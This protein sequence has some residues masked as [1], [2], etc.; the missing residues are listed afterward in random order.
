MDTLGNNPLGYETKYPNS[1]TLD[2]DRD[3]ITD[4]IFNLSGSFGNMSGYYVT[5]KATSVNGSVIAFNTMHDTT[6]SQVYIDSIGYTIHYYYNKFDV[7]R[8]FGNL[9]TISMMRKFTSKT[10]W[11]SEYYQMGSHSIPSSSRNRNA[12]GKFGYIIVRTPRCYVWMKLEKIG[13][14]YLVIHKYR[15]ALPSEFVIRD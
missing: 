14:C 11:I 5:R 9:D 7:V 3:G 13:M 2:L 4:I 8:S 6:W 12:F 1:C 10:L 15:Y